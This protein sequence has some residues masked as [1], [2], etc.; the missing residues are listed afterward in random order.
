MYSGCVA[1]WKFTTSVV[2]NFVF[3]LDLTEFHNIFIVVR[4]AVKEL[5]SKGWF[6]WSPPTV[7]LV[8]CCFFRLWSVCHYDSSLGYD[9]QTFRLYFF[10]VNFLL[11]QKHHL[12]WLSL[13]CSPM[14]LLLLLELQFL[15]QELYLYNYNQE[16]LLFYNYLSVN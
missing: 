4:S 2:M 8:W 13:N 15:H 5:V 12:Y 9:S 3:S 11:R 14:L 10:L 7:S 1:R 16:L 6:I